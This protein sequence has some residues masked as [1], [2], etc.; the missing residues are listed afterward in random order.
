MALFI[1]YKNRI[2]EALFLSVKQEGIITGQLR[3]CKY[4]KEAYKIFCR[5]LIEQKNISNLCR[6]LLK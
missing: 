4:G 1:N 6:E 5:D 3:Y 2:K